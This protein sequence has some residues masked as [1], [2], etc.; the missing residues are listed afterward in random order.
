MWS[1]SLAIVTSRLPA[2]ASV[3]CRPFDEVR[4][5]QTEEG[6]T[7]RAV[8]KGPPGGAAAGSELGRGMGTE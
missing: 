1:P 3:F 4:H 5:N 8:S 2:A 6:A 7:S